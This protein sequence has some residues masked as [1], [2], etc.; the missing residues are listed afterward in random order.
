MIPGKG[1]IV[2]KYNVYP[3]LRAK[4]GNAFSGHL[5][6]GNSALLTLVLILVLA[7]YYGY[8]YARDAGVHLNFE[9]SGGYVTSIVDTGDNTESAINRDQQTVQSESNLRRFHV[10][11]GVM[12]D[13]ASSVETWESIVYEEAGSLSLFLTSELQSQPVQAVNDSVVP[14]EDTPATLNVLTNDINP[15]GAN[16]RFTFALDNKENVLD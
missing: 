5:T 3:A 15:D 10:T 4:T 8:T 13:L 16:V 6:C 11:D 9:R 12:E 14:A 1:S 2:C 7:N